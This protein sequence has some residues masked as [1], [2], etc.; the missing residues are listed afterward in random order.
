MKRYRVVSTWRDNRIKF[1]E[2]EGNNEEGEEK[3]IKSKEQMN[4][5]I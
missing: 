5:F 3:K 1:L 2:K 4:K